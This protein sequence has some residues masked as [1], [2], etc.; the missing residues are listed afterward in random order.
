MFKIIGNF[1]N[2]MIII[3][4]NN[5]RLRSAENNSKKFHCIYYI[6]RTT[7]TGSLAEGRREKGDQSC[8]TEGG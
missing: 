6:H 8:E 1:N 4:R 3:L 2:I 7:L 5:T